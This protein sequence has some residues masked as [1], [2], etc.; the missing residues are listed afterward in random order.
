M[1]SYKKALQTDKEVTSAYFLKSIN[2]NEQQKFLEYLLRDMD[3]QKS[4]RIADIACG[5][6]TLTYHLSR[7]FPNAHFTLA[8]YLDFSIET[9]KKVNDGNAKMDFF[10]D[11]I[12]SLEKIGG[13]FDYTF[14]WQTLSW[15]ENP[16]LALE[17]LIRI[18]KTGGTIYLSSLFNIQCDVDV[19]SKALDLT[20]ESSNEQIFLSYNT[21]SEKS[22]RNWIESKVSNI[23]FFEFNPKIDITYDGRGLGTRTVQTVEDKRIQISAGMLLN[24]YILKITV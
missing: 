5:G 10:A 21:Y 16:K 8:D 11:D 22:I 3:T 9:A 19:Y 13:S 23:E 14:C 12:Y 24:W 7:M 18:T 2:K 6:G 1:D 15:I 4:Y 17:N 20:R